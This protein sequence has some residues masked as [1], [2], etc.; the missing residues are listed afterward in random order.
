MTSRATRKARRSSSSPRKATRG[1]TQHRRESDFEGF[2]DEKKVLAFAGM[3][4][5][6]A[7]A[8]EERGQREGEK[9]REKAR[10]LFTFFSSEG[11]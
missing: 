9:Q 5:V 1:E 10:I 4:M 11:S 7:V 3:L 2:D 8:W 6:I